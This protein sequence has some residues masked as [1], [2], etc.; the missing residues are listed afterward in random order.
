M[1]PLNELLGLI[2]LRARDDTFTIPYIKVFLGDWRREQIRW[3]TSL[4]LPDF[5]HEVD[6]EIF[7]LNG[8][9]VT[10]DWN[11]FKDQL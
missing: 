10:M 9:N 6:G 2:E 1:N 5:L 11:I 8:D 3:K 7:N 4:K